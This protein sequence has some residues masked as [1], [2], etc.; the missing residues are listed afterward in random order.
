M[1]IYRNSML[2]T[3]ENSSN[4]VGICNNED[5]TCDIACSKCDKDLAY[6]LI[7]NSK[8][9]SD[10]IHNI[11]FIRFIAH[12][13]EQSVG[14]V[15]V[16]VLCGKNYAYG[17]KN[18]N[19]IVKDKNVRCC[20]QCYDEVVMPARIEVMEKE[21]QCTQVKISPNTILDYICNSDAVK[22]SVPQA[23][24][25]A[26]YNKY[27][28]VDAEYNEPFLMFKGADT[29]VTITLDF[30]RVIISHWAENGIMMS[31]EGTSGFWTLWD[32]YG[33]VEECG[34]LESMSREPLKPNELKA[35]MTKAFHLETIINDDLGINDDDIN[36]VFVRLHTERLFNNRNQTNSREILYRYMFE[37]LIG[38]SDRKNIG[39]NIAGL[40][41]SLDTDYN[42]DLIAEVTYQL[43]QNLDFPQTNRPTY[44]DANLK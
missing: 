8:Q 16:C 34:F 3:N 18:P 21:S 2:G 20:T 25:F 7:R 10:S 17:G 43:L 27:R 31:V 38:N 5:V 22:L 37:V 24:L 28:I 19:P 32:S 15:G 26:S 29:D 6:I 35:C 11:N 44:Y 36:R 40:F 39:E 42:G 41:L 4:K 14:P 1:S 23:R 30:D 13:K 12:M 33:E 9:V